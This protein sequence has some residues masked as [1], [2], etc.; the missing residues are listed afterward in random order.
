MIDSFKKVV[1]VSNIYYLIR[2]NQDE[3]QLILNNK[4]KIN[5]MNLDYIQKLSFEAQKISIKAHKIDSLIL[6]IFKMII[7]NF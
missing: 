4:N 5:I 6:K 7:T 3:I 2:L 1:R